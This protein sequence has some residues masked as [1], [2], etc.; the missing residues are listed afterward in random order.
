MRHL[1]SS[2]MADDE[3]CHGGKVKHADR[4]S[5]EQ[6]TRRHAIPASAPL[7][8]PYVVVARSSWVRTALT[9]TTKH[10]IDFLE[11]RVGICALSSPRCRSGPRGL[12][13]YLSC[14]TCCEIL[15]MRRIE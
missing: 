8:H 4:R 5:E 3:P 14:V 6:P 11:Y 10:E 15:A 9:H 1:A 13:I 7:R 2:S 12:E